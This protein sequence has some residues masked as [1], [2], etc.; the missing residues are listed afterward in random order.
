MTSIDPTA[1]IPGDS[2]QD[3][4][5]DRKTFSVEQITDYLMMIHRLARSENG[6]A[7]V[8]HALSAWMAQINGNESHAQVEQGRYKRI[9]YMA[10]VSAN[11]T[12]PA[13][14]LTKKDITL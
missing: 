7:G 13:P 1:G 12:I 2:L 8:K 6:R 9:A 4:H 5:T 11:E 10:G 3:Y 14:I